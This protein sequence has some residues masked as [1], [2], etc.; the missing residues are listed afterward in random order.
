M[1][2][3]PRGALLGHLG[4]RSS[5]GCAHAG[6]EHSPGKEADGASDLEEGREVG[7]CPRLTSPCTLRGSALTRD[8]GELQGSSCPSP[9]GTGAASQYSAALRGHE[10]LCGWS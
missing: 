6:C 1:L 5:P 4:L 3:D 7:S 2:P 8:T 9:G 10:L